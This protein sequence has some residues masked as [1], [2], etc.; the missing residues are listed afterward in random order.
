MF[1]NLSPLGVNGAK[2]YNDGTVVKPVVLALQANQILHNLKMSE[3]VDI[4]EIEKLYDEITQNET[5][6][7]PQD[8][9]SDLAAYINDYGNKVLMGWWLMKYPESI[10]N[11]DLH[12]N[13]TREWWM[14]RHQ[15]IN[16]RLNFE[17][18]TNGD[19]VVDLWHARRGTKGAQSFK[20][21]RRGVATFFMGSLGEMWENYDSIEDYVGESEEEVDADIYVKRGRFRFKPLLWFDAQSVTKLRDDE[22]RASVIASLVKSHHLVRNDDGFNMSTMTDKEWKGILYYRTETMIGS[23]PDGTTKPVRLSLGLRLDNNCTDNG[24]IALEMGFGGTLAVDVS[25][26]AAATLPP[27]Q[28]GNAAIQTES[29]VLW[30]PAAFVVE[31]GP[32]TRLDN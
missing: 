16:P 29:V 22:A 20:D 26:I 19:V 14:R 23:L 10:S 18:E 8:T 30:D 17:H 25:G 27:G 7:L 13:C 11:D 3:G 28:V 24:R 12:R 6:T 9:I 4:V 15:G 31:E 2:R 5:H 21:F 1:P 32:W